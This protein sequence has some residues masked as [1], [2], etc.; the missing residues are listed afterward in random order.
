MQSSRVTMFCW[1]CW[2]LYE[3]TL[4]QELSPG[5]STLCVVK[6]HC[7]LYH[8]V[9]NF[10]FWLIT[11]MLGIPKW[12]NDYLKQA[13]LITEENLF[14][15]WMLFSAKWAIYQLYHGDN[16]SYAMKWCRSPVCTGPTRSI[17]PVIGLHVAHWNNSP[18]VDTSLPRTY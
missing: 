5:P 3:A 6:Y 14:M 9:L 4:Q 11:V 8:V 2:S 17:R 7:F 13:N 15:E 18:H 1:Q 12:L 10:M 16:K